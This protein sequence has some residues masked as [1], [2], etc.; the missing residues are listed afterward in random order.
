MDVDQP[1]KGKVNYATID[2]RKSEESD[3][4]NINLSSISEPQSQLS[5]QSSPECS[6][7]RQEKSLESEK[8][9]SSSDE[10]SPR[11][12]HKEIRQ[13]LLEFYRAGLSELDV[14]HKNITGLNKR[15]VY[16]HFQKLRQTGISLRKSGSGRRFKLT[17]MHKQIIFEI[18]KSDHFLTVKEIADRASSNL[19]EVNRISPTTVWR[20][21]RSQGFMSKLPIEKHI[22]TETQKSVLKKFWEQNIDRDWT[23]VIFTDETTFRVGKKKRRCWL[24]PNIPNYTSIRKLSKKVNAW[25]AISTK[26]KV[27]LYLFINNLT[28]EEYVKILSDNLKDLRKIGRKNFLFQCDND[29]KHKCKLALEFYS[30]NKLDRLEWPPYSPDLNP[31]ENVWGIVKQQVNKCD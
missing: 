17:N 10:V 22:L 28:K 23:N 2:E 11:L 12:L 16:R 19:P 29:P 25:G 31:I 13:K 1:P 20:F 27:N 14:I 6:P 5:D 7:L 4:S 26:G 8:E 21:I 9:C 30:K 15:T 3:D 24:M 18:I